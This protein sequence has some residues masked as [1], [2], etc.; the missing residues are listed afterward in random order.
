M[1]TAADKQQFERLVAEA[2]EKAAKERE[3]GGRKGEEEKPPKRLL[4]NLGHPWDHITG[5]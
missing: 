5:D 4:H 3:A 2:R 1:K